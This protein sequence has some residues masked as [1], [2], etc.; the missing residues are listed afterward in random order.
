MIDVEG[1]AYW[2]F[3][4]DCIAIVGVTSRRGN[5]RIVLRPNQCN[6]PVDGLNVMENREVIP[7]R[8]ERASGIV[9]A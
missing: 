1:V 7:L 3:C 6:H 4:R 8:K 2:L 5:T 9:K